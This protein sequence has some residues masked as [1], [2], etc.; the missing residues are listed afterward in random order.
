MRMG[1]F[2]CAACSRGREALVR[3]GGAVPECCG[4]PMVRVYRHA[5]ATV[6]QDSIEGGVEIRHGLVHPD[7]SPRTF[8]SK[9]EMKA[10]QQATGWTPWSDVFESSRIRD[11]EVRLDWYQSSEAQR[12]KRD[13]DEARAEKRLERGR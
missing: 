5:A 4:R 7:G 12:A 9:T 1:D 3:D 6:Q 13:R 10:A 2:V 11:A 8:Y